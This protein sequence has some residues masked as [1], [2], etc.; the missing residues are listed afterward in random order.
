MNYV[1]IDTKAVQVVAE[2]KRRGFQL[3]LASNMMLPGK[4]LKAKL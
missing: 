4:L 2:L 3:A 1:T